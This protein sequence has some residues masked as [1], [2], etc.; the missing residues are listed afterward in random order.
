VFKPELPALFD[1]AGQVVSY[2]EPLWQRFILAAIVCFLLDLLM[3]RVRIFDR[4]FKRT[5]RRLRRA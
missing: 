3:R 4:D 1:P 5:P 2:D